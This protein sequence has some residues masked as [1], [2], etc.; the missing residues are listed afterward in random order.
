MDR[1]AVETRQRSLLASVIVP[2]F[3][4]AATLGAC[5]R[6]LAHQS[7]DE[8]C[9]EILV[10]N[11]GSTDSSAEIADQMGLA[12]I[13]QDH[14]GAAA[15]RNLGARHARGRILLFTDADCEPQ[16]DWIEQMLVPF[17]DPDVVGVKGAYRTRQKSLVARFT[18]AEYEEKYDRLQRAERIDFVDTHSAAYRRDLFLEHGGFDP[19]F[20]FD[21]DQEFSFRLARA[22]HKL[23]FVRSAVVFHRHPATVWEYTWRKM[24]LG[25][26]KVRVHLRH[27]A[28]AI[29]DSYTPWTQKAQIVLL[30]LTLGAAL[31]AMYGA[32]PWRFAAIPALAGI[33]SSAPVVAKAFGQDWTV[34]VVAPALVV[35]RAAALGL[36]LAW[37]VVDQPR[38]QAGSGEYPAT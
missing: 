6:A 12:V 5:L 27:P 31:A 32:L 34:G 25:R 28:K 21:E 16:P 35:V 9:Y 20:L 8:T 17:S 14:A 4:G 24:R 11:D 7:V 13:G 23:C 15:A 22:G 30:P 2:V 10:V 18:Q 29:R 3:D 1:V 37:G 38:L 19:T 33:I 36:G 26:W